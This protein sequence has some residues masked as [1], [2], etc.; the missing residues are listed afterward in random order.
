MC[1]KILC[2][3]KWVDMFMIYLHTKFHV[4]SL[5]GSILFTPN[6]K[7]KN[8]YRS[9]PCCYFILY[10][11]IAL[12]GVAC[13]A[14]ICCC[15]SLLYCKVS[16]ISSCGCHVVI[17]YTKWWSMMMNVSSTGIMFRQ[18]FIKVSQLVQ[19]LKLGIS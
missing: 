19:K 18:S 7:L 15:T 4:P 2:H 11:Y 3:T 6:R 8:T 9:L 14:Q 12:S 17:E 5:H 1:L 10:K 13:F 16:G